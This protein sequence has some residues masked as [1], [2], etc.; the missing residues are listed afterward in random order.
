MWDLYLTTVTFPGLIFMA[1][2]TWQKR[3]ENYNRYV[4]NHKWDTRKASVFSNAR[5]NNYNTMELLFP[6]L[7]PALFRVLALIPVNEQTW[8]WESAKRRKRLINTL[9]FSSNFASCIQA[10]WSN[11]F[12]LTNNSILILHTCDFGNLFM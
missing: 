7:T 11:S 12:S 1:R 3:I 5:M 8:N 9:K 10:S 2:E 4:E 6:A